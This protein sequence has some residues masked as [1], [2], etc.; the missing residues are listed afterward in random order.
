M[1][2]IGI[3]WNTVNF[4]KEEIMGDISKFGE[5][6]DY[7]ELN[8][9]EDYEEFVKKIYEFDGI[10][11]WKIKLKL[12]S[13]KAVD[14]AIITVL[15]IKIDDSKIEFNDRK[16]KNV[17]T[18]IENLKKYIREKYSKRIDNYYFDNVFHM[19]DNKEELLAMLKVLRE[20]CSSHMSPLEAENSNDLCKKLVLERKC[21]NSE[22][23]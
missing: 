8:L 21:G 18:N 7:F 3:L 10:A 19:T 20:W 6:V 11:D 16:Q 5:I 12:D 22:N 1:E 9:G 23:K 15:F 14:C 2:Y 17:I 13:M 4:L